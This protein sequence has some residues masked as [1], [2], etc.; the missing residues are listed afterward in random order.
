MNVGIAGK[1]DGNC[2][3]VEQTAV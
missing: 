2:S 1:L 3:S